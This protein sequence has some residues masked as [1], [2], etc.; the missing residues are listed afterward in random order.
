MQYVASYVEF[1][2]KATVAAFRSRADVYEANDLPPLLAAVV[3]ARL[4][5]RPVV[6]RA[7]E[8]WSEANPNVPF[9]AFWRLM[10]RTLCRD[11]TTW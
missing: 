3:A 11:A 5:G 4:R 1:L 2:T 8:L 7:H 6:Y 10:E 9:A